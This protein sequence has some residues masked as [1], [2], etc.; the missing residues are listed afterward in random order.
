MP[1]AP[2]TG[3]E[4]VTSRWTGGCS[5]IELRRPKVKVEAPLVWV[6]GFEPATSRFQGENADRA[7]LHPAKEASTENWQG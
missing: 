4:P 3:V 7:A 1:L 6:A 2:T 5:S